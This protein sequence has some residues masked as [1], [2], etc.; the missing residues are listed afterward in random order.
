MTSRAQ[1]VTFKITP[2]IF[3]S[4]EACLESVEK[5]GACRYNAKRSRA[6]VSR[7]DKMGKIVQQGPVR[8]DKAFALKRQFGKIT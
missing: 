5:S 6:I 2:V 3:P 1:P 7:E 4:V 8:S